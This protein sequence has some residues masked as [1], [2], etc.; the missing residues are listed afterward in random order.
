MSLK[1]A[2]NENTPVLHH[3]Q[4]ETGDKIKENRF[5]F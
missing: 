4:R 5:Q 1:E 3:S 2:K